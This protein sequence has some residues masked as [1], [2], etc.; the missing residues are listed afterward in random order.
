MAIPAQQPP[1]VG[2]EAELNQ[3]AEHLDQ[4]LTGTGSLVLI[5]GEA[6][7][8][9]SRLAE[10]FGRQ[11]SRKGGLV[12][13]GRCVP[14]APSPYLP[15]QDALSK[16]SWPREKELGLKYWLRGP[17]TSDDKGQHQW[18]DPE[19][20]SGRTLF[21]ALE[22]FRKVSTKQ[23]LM[24]VLE[25]LH[26]ADSATIR[27]LHF[28]A[29]NFGDLRVMLLG[30]YRPEEL[31]M[32]NDKVHPL[33]DGLRTMRREGVV[34]EIEL[35]NLNLDELRF[36]VEG[37][38]GGHVDSE[39]LGGIDHESGG[40]P[41]FV[42]EVVR[43]LIQTKSVA[44]HNGTWKP[45][46]PLR[47]EI[48]PTVKEVVL[49]RV[50]QLAR[51][52]RQVLEAASVFGLRLDTGILGKLL[53]VGRL[54][55]LKILN[56]L[57]RDHQLIQAVENDYAFIHTIVRQVV[58]EHVSP[59]L[60]RELHRMVGEAL[61][62]K[63]GN[64]RLYSELSLHFHDAGEDRKCAKYSLLEAISSFNRSAMPEAAAYFE[65]V[66]EVVGQEPDL[67][68]E[69]LRALEGSGDA[70]MAMGRHDSAISFYENFLKL[71]QNPKDSARV[72]RKSAEAWSISPRGNP[73][74]TLQLLEEAKATLG[75][76]PLEMARIKL[77]LGE[78]AV[79]DGRFE[80]AEV[81]YSDAAK[82]FE[83]KGDAGELATAL[84]YYSEFYLSRGN[85]REALERATRA[86]RI[87]SGLQ[88]SVELGVLSQLG[89]VYFHLG[90]AEKALEYYTRWLRLAEKFGRYY[91]LAWA[92]F[93][94]SLVYESIDH[95]ESCRREAEKAVEIAEEGEALDIRVAANAILAHCYVR[96]KKLEK[97]EGIWPAAAAALATQEPDRFP[98][99]KG[100]EPLRAL[101]T[102]VMAELLSAKKDWT[103]AKERFRES[104]ELFRGAVYGP[105]FEAWART[106]FGEALLRNEGTSEAKKELGEAV[107]LYEELTNQSQ[108]E[109]AK[110]I[111]SA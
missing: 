75:A 52:E 25:D 74:K 10:E 6:G 15:F 11:A 20:E 107:R 97:A 59:P 92:H 102:L 100:H 3:L 8:G 66:I 39:L 55:L 22:F 93:W 23:P 86:S 12:L 17:A 108:A 98:R 18:L 79:K 99:T 7:I 109:K 69:R 62:G 84:L 105:L 27:L 110:K 94:K 60:R 78:L 1:L 96:L 76:D 80:E 47:I 63:L 104:I 31:T 36:V 82:R 64:E 40:N 38:L 30:T 103:R 70:R 21:A 14:G 37:M 19:S 89:D 4:A 71:S 46:G 72:L 9:K 106:R 85:V 13:V 68:Q 51:D 32:A 77:I 91:S 83:E 90:E 65:R 95:L 111:L 41:L 45:V 24:V 73:S 29:R 67:A 53:E 88:S 101:V 87:L 61:E 58:Y 56:A 33:L 35:D 26:W 5:A 43:L 50:D 81:L 57:E 34:H 16:V 2:R 48:P 42:V 49:R 54:G 28:L 44:M